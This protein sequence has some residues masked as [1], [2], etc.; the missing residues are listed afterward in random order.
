MECHRRL[1]QLVFASPMKGIQPVGSHSY[2][3]D[4][5]HFEHLVCRL[6]Y[7]ERPGIRGFVYSATRIHQSDRCRKACWSVTLT[8]DRSPRAPFR[9]ASPLQGKQ[10]HSRGCPWLFTGTGRGTGTSHTPSNRDEHPNHRLVGTAC[11]SGNSKKYRNRTFFL[12]CSPWRGPLKARDMSTRFL[13]TSNKTL[14]ITTR[15]QPCSTQ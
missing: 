4:T 13:A 3:W 11:V 9:V 2:T 10:G 14:T 6:S 8:G 1:E 12:S 7:D 5:I 15:I